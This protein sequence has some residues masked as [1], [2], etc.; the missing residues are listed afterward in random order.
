MKKF[1]FLPLLF[2]S[3]NLGFSAPNGNPALPAIIE[4]G[5]FIPDTKWLNFR[6]D[7][8]N[9]TSSDL[10]MEFWDVFQ[11]MGYV[12]R[13]IKAFSNTGSI[14]L[15]FK[16]RL[17]IY[18]EMG[19]CRIEPEF[20]RGSSLYISKSENDFLYRIGSKLIF[21]EMM[22]FTL[23]ADVKYSLFYA[24]ASYLTLNDAPINEN[25]LNFK[26]K[27]WQL[28]LGLAQ[29]ISILRPYLGVVYKDTQ[30]RIKNV[31]FL[32]N[33]SLKIGFLKKAG[34]FL[35]TSMSMGSFIMLNIEARLVNE[36]SYTFSGEIRF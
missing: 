9:Y 28:G 35:G 30:V 13:K 19:S 4:E 31:P 8:Q 21:F 7:Y 29:K 12:L 11:E 34:T 24:P 20:R 1:L 26:L 23:G 17:D 15:N 10:M 14:T 2:F 5:F 16:E 33:N 3:F 25:N 22:D 27:E 36:R 32:Q 6:F 18:F